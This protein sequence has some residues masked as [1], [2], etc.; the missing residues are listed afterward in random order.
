MDIQSNNTTLL[1]LFFLDLIMMSSNINT[2]LACNVQRLLDNNIF[3][4][5]IIVYFS[6]FIFTF[7]LGW[8][9]PSAIIVGDKKNNMLHDKSIVNDSSN[10]N[11]IIDSLIR[12][13]FIYVLFILSAKQSVFF[14]GTFI[15]LLLVLIFVYLFYT[16]L[17]DELNINRNAITS[18][19][20]SKTNLE[21]LTMNKYVNPLFILHNSISLGHIFIFIN[22]L[23][24]VFYYYKKQVV[25]HKDWSWVKFIFGVNKCNK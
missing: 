7:I 5:H 13:F 2:L 9:L 17:L 24:G 16:K 6:I 18:L 8:F 3:I 12:S 20:V 14:M 1:V 10:N 21:S 4:K 15:I 22:I 23:F 19:F 11:Y 25:D